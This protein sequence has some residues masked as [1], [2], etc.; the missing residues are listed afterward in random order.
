M[1]WDPT[2]HV[3][4]IIDSNLCA[5]RGIDPRALTS[6]C[7]RG[8]ARLLQVRVKSGT[9]TSFL[10]LAEDIVALAREYH[11]TVIV[12]DR[13]D[14]ARMCGAAGVHVGQDDLTPADAR[15]V[16]GSGLIGVSTHDE[17]QIEEAMLS[18]ADY[19]AVG[20]IFDT[21]TKE[22]GYGARGLELVRR[23]AGRGKP[24]VAIGGVTLERA[25]AV[26]AA[27]ASA[28][29]VIGDVLGED[30]EARVRAYVHALQCVETAASKKSH[31]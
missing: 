1:T 5:R 6:A 8:G 7:L 31:V 15:A 17:S 28:V 26:I 4:P 18:V 11:A 30:P 9:S 22:T 29:A 14:I 12:N 27:G 3:Y 23:A 19:I 16:L 10:T 25:P 24:I 2:T 20:P 21:V 13:A